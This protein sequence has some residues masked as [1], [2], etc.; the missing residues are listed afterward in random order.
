VNSNEYTNPLDTKFTVTSPAPRYAMRT[1]A[2]PAGL[3]LSMAHE[4]TI[5]CAKSICPC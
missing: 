5:R 2:P 4:M 3:S 1:D